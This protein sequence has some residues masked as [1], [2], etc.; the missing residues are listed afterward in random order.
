MFSR[1][2]LLFIGSCFPHSQTF[3]SCQLLNCRAVTDSVLYFLLFLLA[4]HYL[5]SL[6]DSTTSAKLTSKST[7]VALIPLARPQ[8]FLSNRVTESP[9]TRLTATSISTWPKLNLSSCY[10]SMCFLPPC[11]LS[12]ARQRHPVNRPAQRPWGV[13]MSLASTP[14]W[15]CGLSPPLSPIQAL[16]IPYSAY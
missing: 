15:S 11:S 3:P 16:T 1:P 4:S 5:S 10:L 7:P 6:M 9:Q 13:F 12:R 14:T 2:H 8:T